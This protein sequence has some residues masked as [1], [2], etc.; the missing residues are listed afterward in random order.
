MM[1]MASARRR[2]AW[3]SRGTPPANCA[4]T[5]DLAELRTLGFRGEA[6][7]TI[8]AVSQLSAITRHI[9]DELGTLVRIEGGA[10]R[11]QQS[12]AAPRG[13]MVTV[14][15]LFYNTPARLKFLKR[16]ATERRQIARVVSRYAF[17]FPEA[18]FA[19]Q[20][21]GR[22]LF[23][24]SGNGD[25]Y[26]ALV[27]LLGLSHARQLLPTPETNADRHPAL[28][29]AIRVSGFVSAPTLHRGDRNQLALYV[30]GRWIQD[31][32]LNFAIIRAYE[33]LLTPGRFPFAFLQ[34]TM[35]PEHV[36]RQR[37]SD[38]SGSALSTTG[39]RL[40]GGAARGARRPLPGRI[41]IRCRASQLE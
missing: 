39:A 5:Q 20:Q 33:G 8:A 12:Q 21:D 29:A 40:C 15:N 37:P 25:R 1:A 30:N 9:D 41:A 13:S 38:Q 16:P 22:E 28:R 7:A 36:R 27:Q 34:I 35:P 32:R 31:S 14:E 4:P 18:R 17:A 6:L 26:D 11:K 10:W 3:R 24:T 23:H 2:S 19:Y